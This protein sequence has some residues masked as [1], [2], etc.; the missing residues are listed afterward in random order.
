MTLM[1]FAELEYN[2]TQREVF[3]AKMDPLIPCGKLEKKLAK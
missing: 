1:T 3:L 2:K